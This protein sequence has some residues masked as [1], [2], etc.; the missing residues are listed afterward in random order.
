MRR[1]LIR[2]I[3]IVYIGW[4]VYLAVGYFSRPKPIVYRKDDSSSGYQVNNPMPSSKRIWIQTRGPK[5]SSVGLLKIGMDKSGGKTLYVVSD[6]GIFRCA[7]GAGAW[8][9]ITGPFEADIFQQFIVLPGGSNG[10]RLYLGTSAGLFESE[11]RGNS[12]R[13]V[14]SDSFGRNL[15][16]FAAVQ[17]NDLDNLFVVSEG[18]L[19]ERV[20]DGPWINRARSLQGK[21]PFHGVAVAQA[22][23][24]RLSLFL[25]TADGLYRGVIGEDAWYP[26]DKMRWKTIWRLPNFPLFLDDAYV[27]TWEDHLIL[28]REPYL[29]RTVDMG[30]SWREISLSD[31]FWPTSLAVY[32]TEKSRVLMLGLS[33]GDFAQSEDG[34]EKW[35]SIHLDSAKAVSSVIEFSPLYSRDHLFYSVSQGGEVLEIDE[36]THT[37]RTAAP[38]PV[39]SSVRKVAISPLFNQDTTLYAGTATGVMVTHNGGSSWDPLKDGLENTDIQY[40]GLSPS[41]PRDH[42]VFVGTS[43]GA[44]ISENEGKKWKRMGDGLGGRDVTWI[45]SSSVPEFSREV[46]VG[47][48]DGVYRSQAGDTSW[49]FSSA[50]ISGT[51]TNVLAA[52]LRNG[53]ASLYAGTLRGLYIS[54]NHGKSWRFITSLPAVNVLSLVLVSG[55]NHSAQLWAGT[56][57]GLFVSENMGD[58]WRYVPLPASRFTV[59]TISSVGEGTSEESLLVGTIG[60]GIYSSNDAGMTWNHLASS[61]EGLQISDLVS[62]NGH[63]PVLFAATYNRGVL[64]YLA[65]FADNP[66][67]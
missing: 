22:R 13:D 20:G 10:H 54:S 16:D 23:A 39:S 37:W 42:T 45:L 58:S 40:I 28:W 44:Y 32:E 31:G 43:D 14:D 59:S 12:W 63:S 17:L 5:G 49:K 29:Y 57:D 24:T 33:S 3:V 26:V 55:T 36:G 64:R 1:I 51:H 56:A 67:Q 50:G 2:V 46:W 8:E 53:V 4:V 35:N 41:Y 7:A 48:D 65:G 66:V 18:G 27:V 38:A 6:G 15:K 62:N 9:L 25:A 11:D 61:L 52:Y 19:F 30:R 21:L 60:G 47:T 34:G